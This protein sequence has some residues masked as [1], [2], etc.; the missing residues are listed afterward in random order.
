MKKTT[1][2]WHLAALALVPVAA[3]QAATVVLT[4]DSPRFT[5][6]P[7]GGDAGGRI[8]WPNGVEVLNPTLAYLDA[9]GAEIEGSTSNLDCNDGGFDEGISERKPKD[10]GEIEYIKVTM[11]EVFRSTVPD[12]PPAGSPLQWSVV[13]EL[14]EIVDGMEVWDTTWHLLTDH[15]LLDPR[16]GA[17]E[18]RSR[19]YLGIRFTSAGAF[20]GLDQVSIG[21][22][23]ASATLSFVAP[24]QTLAGRLGLL[25]APT[26]VPEPGT[27]PLVA[28]AALAFLIRR[29]PVRTGAR[30]SAAAPA[31]A[32]AARCAARA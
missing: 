11:K 8:V 23:L 5:C 13:S 15:L 18:G 25:A 14:R 4:P 16:T 24:T 31:P 30:P 1:T 9:A 20:E 10:K 12:S 29:R 6:A 22:D 2:L 7:E 21:Y 19:N 3:A 28:A 27:L 32:P 26:A 17:L